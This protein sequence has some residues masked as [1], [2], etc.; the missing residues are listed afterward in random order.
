M[1]NFSKAQLYMNL[2]ETAGIM[3]WN[4]PEVR[5]ELGADDVLPGLADV[6]TDTMDPTNVNV[7]AYNKGPEDWTTAFPDEITLKGSRG[8]V[9]QSASRMDGS[10]G[11]PNDY[12]PTGY[13]PRPLRLAERLLQRN[14]QSE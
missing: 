14:E 5:S 9:H 4:T 6:K 13:H 12:N 7:P 2:L 10:E 3:F 1:P 8:F 11:H